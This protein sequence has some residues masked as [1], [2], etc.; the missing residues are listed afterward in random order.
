MSEQEWESLCKGCGKCCYEK[1]EEEDGTI[2]YTDVP[3]RFLDVTTKRCKLYE[4]RFEVCSDCL[5]LTEETLTERYWLPLSCGYVEYFRRK[6][7]PES[8]RPEAM[9]IF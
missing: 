3:C 5:K 9:V 8:W 2:I 1:L 6:Y 7:G 4:H